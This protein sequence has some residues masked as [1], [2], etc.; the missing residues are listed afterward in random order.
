M[1]SFWDERYSEKEYAYGKEPNVFFKEQLDKL[2]SGTLLLTCEGEG[3]NAVY[4]C[5]NNWEVDA[6]D[7]SE[8]G[9]E[10]CN[11]LSAEF[12]VKVN[13]TLADAME[14]DY[15]TEKYDSIALIYS[16]FPTDVRN[17]VLQQS[18][19]ALKSG[20]TIILEAFNPLQLQ[21]PTGGPRTI[22]MLYTKQI[23]I[24]AFSDFE[25]QLLE[26]LEIELNEGNYHKGKSNII[27]MIAMKK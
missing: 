20:G 12:D 13:Y 27:R 26:E 17:F 23:L 19:K 24:E 9:L 21:N 11:Q 22:D 1:N 4:A 15:G 6:F 14:F 16:H 3:R 2:P 25:I 7:S 18:K 8:V 5:L 10:K